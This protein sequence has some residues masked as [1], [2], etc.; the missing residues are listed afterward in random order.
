MKLL[1]PL[2]YLNESCAVT[3]N[4]DEKD[5][6]IHLKYAQELLYEILGG[7]FYEQIETQYNPSGDTLT[8][9]NSTL[10]EDY[11]KDYLAWMTY[12]D[13]FGFTN[14]KST[15]TGD[16]QFKEEFSEVT[17]DLKLF[18]KEKRILGKVNHYK[19]R[20]INFLK[21]AQSKDSTAYPLWTGY[22]QDQ[23]SFAISSVTRNVVKDNIITI[24]KA[25]VGNE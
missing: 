2:A 15:P 25:V 8:T 16:R 17:S 10:Y 23:F 9:A 5:Y 4:F 11:I 3:I 1:I 7:E 6:K 22:C 21:L 19:F 14:S 18:S 13:S 12:Y 20:M 24:S